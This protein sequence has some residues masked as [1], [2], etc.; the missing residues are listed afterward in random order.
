MS[1]RITELRAVASVNR[2]ERPASAL[3]ALASLARAASPSLLMAVEISG[4][5]AVLV[6]LAWLP[7]LGAA[8]LPFVVVTT[9][10]F[11]GLAEYFRTSPEVIV[12]RRARTWLRM[13]QNVVAATGIVAAV[14]TLYAI[15]GSAI[16]VLVS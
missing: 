11:W 6:V 5:A 16:G 14:A 12:N 4:A 1:R 9:F 2:I 3:D 10:G 8:P 7:Q 13:L 15:I